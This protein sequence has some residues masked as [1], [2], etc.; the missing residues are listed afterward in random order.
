MTA[1][2]MVGY[3]QSNSRTMPTPAS[4]LQFGQDR[5]HDDL[6]EALS[7]GIRQSLGVCVCFRLHARH[8]IPVYMQRKADIQCLIALRALILYA[9]CV[10][11]TGMIPRNKGAILLSHC[12]GLGLAI[13]SLHGF[14]VEVE[15]LQ[16]VERRRRRCTAGHVHHKS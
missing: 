7:D 9:S 4:S 6:S 15:A 8:M 5:T 1:A 10:Y 14:A 12:V 2:K 16:F 11:V 13:R 3:K